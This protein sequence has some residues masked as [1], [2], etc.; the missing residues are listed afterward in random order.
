MQFLLLNET[1][2]LIRFGQ[3]N[4]RTNFDLDYNNLN[5]CVDSVSTV[6]DNNKQL[7]Q[8]L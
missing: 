7:K 5:T 2:L 1:T 4:L 6:N 3:Q 8:C